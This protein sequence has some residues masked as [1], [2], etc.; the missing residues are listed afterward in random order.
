[1]KKADTIALLQEEIM[2]LKR[3][4]GYALLKASEAKNNVLGQVHRVLDHRLDNI[5]IYAS[6][7]NHDSQK[8]VKWVD[9]IIAKLKEININE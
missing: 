9:E 6:R 2:H 7:P 8:I 5:R 1:M 4:E 3:G